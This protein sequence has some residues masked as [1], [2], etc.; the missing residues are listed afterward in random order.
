M[1]TQPPCVQLGVEVLLIHAL[2]IGCFTSSSYNGQNSYVHRAVGR[3]LE[4]S[5]CRAASADWFGAVTRR[6]CLALRGGRDV[7]DKKRNR[8]SIS[9][10]AVPATARSS[11][12]SSPN[13]AVVAKRMRATKKPK[14]RKNDDDEDDALDND[15]N[16][17][18]GLKTEDEPGDNEEVLVKESIAGPAKLATRKNPRPTWIPP[19]P[20]DV[21]RDTILES[22]RSSG[23]T[24]ATSGKGA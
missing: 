17:Q 7:S 20:I 23:P 21:A 9:A 10:D 19:P 24:D 8:K 1:R 3:V 18:A 16:M 12:E 15:S 13:I 6:G 5:P 2:F 22:A 14:R 4:C 11:G